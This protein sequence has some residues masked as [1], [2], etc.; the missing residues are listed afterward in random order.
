MTTSASTTAGARRHRRVAPGADWN[1]GCC[2][3]RGWCSFRSP[4]SER[5][6]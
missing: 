1:W 6:H 4:R 3:W 2:P 5:R